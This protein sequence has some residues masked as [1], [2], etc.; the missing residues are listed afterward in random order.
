VPSRSSPALGRRSPG[1]G[2]PKA[3]F[4]A[5]VGARLLLALRTHRHREARVPWSAIGLAI[6]CW[7]LGDILNATGLHDAAVAAWISA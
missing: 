3:W 4:G 2:V 6:V 5:R 1:G 7:T